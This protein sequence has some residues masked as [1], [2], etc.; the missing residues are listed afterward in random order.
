M[1]IELIKIQE[2]DLEM[3]AKWRMLPDVTKYMYTDP[4]LTFNIQLNWL[5]KINN[6][7]AVQY[8]IIKI[9]DTK[10][11]VINIYD[12]DYENRRCSWAYYIGDTSFRGRGIATN[13][14]C[15]IY[16]YVFHELKLNKLCCEVFTFNERV[17]EIHKKFGSKIEGTLKNHIWKDK[18]P[19]DIVAMAI[20]KDIWEVT[21]H[22]F[23]YEKIYIE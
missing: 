12:I 8:W 21:R 1:A 5:K 4:K 17:I 22:N 3:I 11:G 15:N 9:D 16:D 10:I 20:T 13:L 18:K 2:F 23:N 7:N 6:D 14:E 19:Y